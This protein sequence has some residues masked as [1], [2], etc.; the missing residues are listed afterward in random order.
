M[1][2]VLSRILN[3]G[4]RRYV[5]RFIRRNF[6][7]VRV[8]GQ[9]YTQQLPTGPVVCFFNHPSWWDPMTVVLITDLLFPGRR[10]YA[11]M[12]A[13]A[14]RHYPILE[15]LGFFAVARDSVAGAKEFLN[16]S[17]EVLKSP[18][19]MLWMTPTGS[20]HDARHAAPFMSGLSHLVDSNFEGSVLTMA[21]EYTF[22]N[23]RC[24]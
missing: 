12:D 18:D 4:F 24:P 10:F 20:F 2:T 1:P 14:L 23:E 21:I 22:W 13:E 5:R 16:K 11:P 19:S 8:S 17:R 7:A 6:N 3:R 15:R 9:E